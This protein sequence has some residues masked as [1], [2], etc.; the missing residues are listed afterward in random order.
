LFRIDRAHVT[1]KEPLPFSNGARSVETEVEDPIGQNGQRE[2]DL[3]QEKIAGA[4]EQLS[5]LQSSA[6][7]VLERARREADIMRLQTQQEAAD[8]RMQAID[9]GYKEG[10]AEGQ[11]R[12]LEEANNRHVEERVQIERLIAEISLAKE[13]VVENIEEEIVE[14][15]LETCKKILN[16]SIQSDDMLYEPILQGAL[17]QLK[18]EG[19][20]CLRV[21]EQVLGRHFQEGDC[22]FR[23]GDEKV[24]AT[25]QAD[26]SLPEGGLIVETGDGAVNAGLESQLQYISVAFRQAEG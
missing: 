6:T 14:L 18:H 21:S 25:V 22:T 24:Y 19:K 8:L 3:L 11:Q 16:R 7:G 10:F 2:Y 9:H 5:K 17:A 26:P 4:R 12:A 1:V 13:K 15:V 20:V 23:C